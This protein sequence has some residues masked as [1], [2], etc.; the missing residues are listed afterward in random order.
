VVE[1][2][3]LDQLFSMIG[4]DGVINSQ[5]VQLI[6]QCRFRVG[7]LGRMCDVLNILPMRSRVIGRNGKDVSLIPYMLNSVGC[8]HPCNALYFRL[9]HASVCMPNTRLRKSRERWCTENFLQAVKMVNSHWGDYV[10]FLP[11]VVNLIFFEDIVSG[12]DHSTSTRRVRRLIDFPSLPRELTEA[13][14]R[15]IQDRRKRNLRNSSTARAY[16]SRQVSGEGS[17]SIAD[18]DDDDGTVYTIQPL[19]DGAVM[20]HV[21]SIPVENETSVVMSSRL[22][23]RIE[24]A[25]VFACPS[26][27][28]EEDGQITVQRDLSFTNVNETEELWEYLRSFLPTQG[29][30]S[31]ISRELGGDIFAT[32]NTERHGDIRINFTCVVEVIGPLNKSGIRRLA[33]LDG[34]NLVSL[35]TSIMEKWELWVEILDWFQNNTPYL[36][37]IMMKEDNLGFF[38][39]NYFDSLWNNSGTS[40]SI[41]AGG[42]TVEGFFQDVDSAVTPG[43]VSD[44]SVA[45]AGSAPVSSVAAAG[46][47]P[48]SSVAA[49]GS[50]PVSS[51][52]AAGSA[53]VSSVAVGS[54]P[55]SSVAVGSAP[56]SSVAA[57]H[58]ALSTANT[59]HDAFQE[60]MMLDLNSINERLKNSM[61]AVVHDFSRQIAGVTEG[62]NA[63]EQRIIERERN[64]VQDMR[65][66]VEA[67]IKKLHVLHD[68]KKQKVK[69]LLE[70][71]QE[72]EL[73]V[74]LG[75]RTLELQELERTVQLTRDRLNETNTTLLAMTQ[76]IQQ[77]QTEIMED[78]PVLNQVVEDFCRLQGQRQAL[79]ALQQE[80]ERRD[81]ELRGRANSLQE[82][83]QQIDSDTLKL[84]EDRA[85]VDADKN[86]AKKKLAQNE[87]MFNEIKRRSDLVLSSEKRNTEWGNQLLAREL[88]VA[89]REARFGIQP[90][91]ANVVTERSFES[92]A[93]HFTSVQHLLRQQLQQTHT[94]TTGDAQVS[95]VNP[96]GGD[97]SRSTN[98][99]PGFTGVGAA[100][101]GI[102]PDALGGAAVGGLPPAPDAMERSRLSDA[103]GGAAVGGL[104]PDATELSRLADA[105]GGAAPVSS[106][107]ES[108]PEDLTLGAGQPSLQ[109]H[110]CSHRPPPPDGAAFGGGS[111]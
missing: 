109:H 87:I 30:Y 101:G 51:V 26:F 14:L 70:K 6:M 86:E 77:V 20:L 61:Q 53:P 81:I 73:S 16:L 18:E 40:M 19:Q 88:E 93:K 103:L 57:L 27:G 47:A 106:S 72:E 74:S 92:F 105:L 38:H 78:I 9:F 21:D 29:S 31:N 100:V 111:S 95:V 59:G 69:M 12:D 35:I 89:R 28:L 85:K 46:S 97:P 34:T 62:L 42:Q 22:S 56:V 4:S 64:M 90:N 102:P 3:N 68:L 48:V 32:L 75:K 23:H 107:Q 2:L 52:A 10:H 43:S 98:V 41:G 11:D 110:E 67:K 108:S 33:N 25:Q 60:T 54:A 65:F 15:E 71:D 83:R 50:A 7:N 80:N 17:F 37:T 99:L 8:V 104:P 36:S 13:V 1:L 94:G 91:N 63:R 96:D 55:V 44:S 49:A 82:I 79:E 39:E 24:A 5:A 45:A 76:H 58:S 66:V 84:N